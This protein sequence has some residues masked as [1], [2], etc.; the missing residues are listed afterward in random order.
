[1]KTYTLPEL[2]DILSDLAEAG[3]DGLPMDTTTESRVEAFFDSLARIEEMEGQTE[4]ETFD[5]ATESLDLF[6]VAGVPGVATPAEIAE[7]LEIHE[8]ER[9]D[10]DENDAAEADD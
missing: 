2:R 10:R 4:E 7:L 1:M 8:W 6:G 3:L 9:D 5:D